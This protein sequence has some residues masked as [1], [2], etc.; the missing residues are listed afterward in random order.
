MK[1]RYLIALAAHLERIQAT[2]LSKRQRHFDIGTVFCRGK[3]NPTGANRCGTAACAM[4]ETPFVPL[5]AK[6]G[7]RISRGDGVLT[8]RGEYRS[9]D[10]LAQKLFG[11]TEAESDDLFSPAGYVV[12][13]TP[14]DVAAKI[15]ALVAQYKAAA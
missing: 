8:L 4:G 10:T 11:I 12:P 14:G 9:Y 6:A 5:L 13:P 1:T 7:V 3:V 2:P 15:R